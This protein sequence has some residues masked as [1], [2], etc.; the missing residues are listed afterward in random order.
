MNHILFLT[1]NKFIR[2]NFENNLNTKIFERKKVQF[3]KLTKY[4]IIYN[5]NC[6]LF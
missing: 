3:I 2:N 4:L 5:L 6:L 1:K